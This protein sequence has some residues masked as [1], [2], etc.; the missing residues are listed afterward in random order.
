LSAEDR[1]DGAAEG[2]TRER[3]AAAEAA[4]FGL[5][6]GA[7]ATAGSVSRLVR[8]GVGDL[9]LAVAAEEV[10]EISAL[11]RLSALPGAPP[12]IAG[13]MILRSRVV[14]LLA[15]D[16]LLAV[17][18]SEEASR[19]SAGRVIVVSVEGMSVG[20]LVD[21][22][23]GVSVV[24]AS[25]MRPVTSVQGDALLRYARAEIDEAEGLLIVLDMPR[26]LDDARPQ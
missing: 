6:S 21:R 20:L 22:I 4:V 10:E 12:H 17:A 11:G 24:A 8:F 1:P 23:S 9:W 3:I 26:L 5:S 16:R 19:E 13:L 25:D 18:T 7:A 14:P 15:L 2:L